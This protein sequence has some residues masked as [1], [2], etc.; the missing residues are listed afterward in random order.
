MGVVRPELERLAVRVWVWGVGWREEGEEGRGRPEEEGAES[1][2]GGIGA[3]QK[4]ECG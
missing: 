3:G 2:G 1:V 4:T